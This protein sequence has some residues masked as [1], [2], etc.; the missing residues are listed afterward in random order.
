MTR[1]GTSGILVY[2]DSSFDAVGV[3]EHVIRIVPDNTK[4]DGKYLFAILSNPIYEPIFE[5]SISGSMVDEITPDI[6]KEL[7]F[8]YQMIVMFK[9]I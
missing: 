3:S 6:I 4:I 9:R 2:A 8:S 5:R 1:S 7:Q